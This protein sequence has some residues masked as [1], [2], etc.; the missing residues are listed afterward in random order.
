MLVSSAEPELLSTELTI[1]KGE[2][3]G[4]SKE[5]NVVLPSATDPI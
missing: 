1:V 2:C 3:I 5:K 4:M